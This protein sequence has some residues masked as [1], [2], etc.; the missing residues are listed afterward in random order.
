[1]REIVPEIALLMDDL[2]LGRHGDPWIAA[3]GGDAKIVE[4]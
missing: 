3:L 4:G 2:K 1:M